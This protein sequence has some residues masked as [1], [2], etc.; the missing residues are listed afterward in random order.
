ML[1]TI[2]AICV[3]LALS[4]S[5][6]VHAD[7]ATDDSELQVSSS[8]LT[9]SVKAGETKNIEITT[10]NKSIRPMEVRLQVMQFSV[11]ETHNDITFEKP[12][13]D[14]VQARAG[15]LL[16]EPNKSKTAD[17]KIT[18]PAN[19]AEKEYYYALLASTTTGDQVAKKTVQVASL[20]YLYVDGGNA[21]YK[22]S[23]TNTRIPTISFA[24]TIPY[25]FA[26]RNSGNIHLQASSSAQLHGWTWGTEDVHT[27]TIVMPE[28]SRDVKGVFTAP[29]SPGIYTLTYGYTDEVTGKSTILTSPIIY[30]PLWSIAVAVLLSL[31]GLWLW[32]RYQG[33][34]IKSDQ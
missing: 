34:R 14:W 7:E 1:R 19:A 20:L 4:V 29:F 9:V 22:S 15:S 6:L 18:V 31:T 33:R 30:I 11:G 25:A 21:Q 27:N 12:K 8:R 10:R 3:S 32:Q 24:T 5:P 13:Y 23:V 17:Y 26:I 16:L 28:R 2:I